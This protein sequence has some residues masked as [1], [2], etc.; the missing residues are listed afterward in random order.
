M[1]QFGTFVAF[2]SFCDFV[3]FFLSFCDYIAK[4]EDQ[5]KAKFLIFIKQ[6]V[7]REDVWAIDRPV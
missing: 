5:T 2:L 6:S 1:G 7:N 4:N 3:I